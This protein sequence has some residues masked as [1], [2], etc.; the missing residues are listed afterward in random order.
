MQVAAQRTAAAA[1]GRTIVVGDVVYSV[2]RGRHLDAPR[3][4]GLLDSGIVKQGC[5][6]L[7]T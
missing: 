5:E 4:R 7:H 1:G 6:Y 2:D 3:G